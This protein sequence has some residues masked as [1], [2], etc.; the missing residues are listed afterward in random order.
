MDAAAVPT[1]AC[2]I[3]L[4]AL[5]EPALAPIVRLSCY[6]TFHAVCLRGGTEY[7]LERAAERRAVDAARGGAGSRTLLD[8]AA[9]P[10][11]GCPLCRVRLS[12]AELAEVVGA[13]AREAA[14][15][16]PT[17]VTAGVPLTVPDTIA[18]ERRRWQATLERQRLAGG[19]IDVDENQRRLRVDATT[20]ARPAPAAAPQH[21][22]RTWASDAV[23]TARPRPPHH[24]NPQAHA[25]HAHPTATHQHGTA[26]RTPTQGRP[27]RQRLKHAPVAVAAA[28][29]AAKHAS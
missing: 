4:Q 19:L 14:Q 26:H 23:P 16:A 11:V 13:A 27:P 6:H 28:D 18:A 10:T 20:V 8:G 12:A 17:G 2:A 15:A 1:S 3:C 25:H 9:A 29:P 5:A 24:T 7:E 22:Q 21:P